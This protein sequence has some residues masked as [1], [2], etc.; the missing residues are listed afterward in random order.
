MGCECCFGQIG[1]PANCWASEAPQSDV[2]SFSMP[3]S[4]NGWHWRWQWPEGHR[5]LLW[6]GLQSWYPVES[7][8]GY[9]FKVWEGKLA[10]TGDPAHSCASG[11]CYCYF[12]ELRNPK[13]E[14]Y[15]VREWP[16]A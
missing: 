15:E 5:P 14:I 13:G 1:W 11:L 3:E 10:K 16:V 6:W 12:L 4:W 9:L 8:S 2:N 7:I